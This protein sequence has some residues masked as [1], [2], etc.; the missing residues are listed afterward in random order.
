[1]LTDCRFNLTVPYQY[2]FYKRRCHGVFHKC[3]Y[4]SQCIAGVRPV[5]AADE[6]EILL[7]ATASRTSKVIGLPAPFLNFGIDQEA[8]VTLS[9]N[10]NIANAILTLT[11]VL[12]LIQT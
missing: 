8:A 4:R 5:F 7:I 12:N 3:R 10:N 11:S 2:Y 1:M 9:K 6:D